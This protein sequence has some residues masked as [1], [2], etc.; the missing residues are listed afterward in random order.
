MKLLCHWL[1][2]TKICLNKS[3]TEFIIFKYSQKSLNYDFKLYTNGT[4]LLPSD[5]IKYLGVFL[6]PD[7]TWISQINH[8]AS[9]LK[10]TNGALS[11]IRHFVLLSIFIFIYYTIFYSHLQYCCQIWGQPNSQYLIRIYSS[12]PCC[13]PFIFST[14][15]NI[16]LKT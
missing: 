10:R 15:G 13:S 3:K 16:S 5:C 4:R 2:S 9:K 6:N 12:K 14:N 1:S 7:L 11:K 8:I